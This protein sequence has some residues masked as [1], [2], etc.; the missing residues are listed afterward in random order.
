MITFHFPRRPSSLRMACYRVSS[1][2]E[3]VCRRLLVPVDLPRRQTQVAFLGL[4]CLFTI[5]PHSL[6]AQ[7]GPPWI[8]L[9]EI[10]DISHATAVVT[11]EFDRAVNAWVEFG[12]TSSYGFK[13]REFTGAANTRNTLPLGGLQPQTTYHFRVAARD[14]VTQQVSYTGDYLFTTL[15]QPPHAHSLSVAQTVAP[16]SPMVNNISYSSARIEATTTSPWNYIRVSY[17]QS[18]GTPNSS[19]IRGNPAAK[20]TVLGTSLSG[21][22]A[23]TTYTYVVCVSQDQATET[24]SPPGTFTTTKKPHAKTAGPVPPVPPNQ[25]SPVQPMAFADTATVASDCSNLQAVINVAAAA[26]R[27]VNHKIILPAQC[28]GRNFTLPARSGA[29]GW[30]FF[31]GQGSTVTQYPLGTG[32]YDL[33]SRTFY[34][35]PG[36]TK[37]WFSGLAFAVAPVTGTNPMAYGRLWIGMAGPRSLCRTAHSRVRHGRRGSCT[38]WWSALAISARYSAAASIGVSGSRRMVRLLHPMVRSAKRWI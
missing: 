35:A 12:P 8:T 9:P 17:S 28:Q 10:E 26:D 29:T 38:A 27:T 11:V 24:C 16:I 2:V 1:P 7:T 21:L 13:T 31:T 20:A 22:K 4:M 36:A 5:S 34:T 25:Y 32:R 18:G 14:P 19:M 37:Y 3:S 30:I 6:H 33:S 15:H 23:S